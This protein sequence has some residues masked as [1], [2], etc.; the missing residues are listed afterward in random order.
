MAQYKTLKKGATD[1][2]VGPL[3]M[4]LNEALSPSPNL[5]TDTVF[6]ADT[7]RAVRRF[8]QENH[9]AEDGVVGSQTWKKLL[10]RSPDGILLASLSAVAASA[11]TVGASDPVGE[12]AGGLPDTAGLS[13]EHKFNVYLGYIQKAG[14]CTS[15]E[16]ALD[17]GERV[18]LGLRVTTNTRTNAGGG[19][20][21][22]RF[23]VLH[24]NGGVKTAKEF[25][26]NTDPSSRYEHRYE[27]ARKAYG[28]DANNDGR[29]DLGRIPAGS[30]KFKKD[31]S[32][33]YGNVLRPMSAIIAERDINHD[34]SFDATDVATNAAALNAGTSM[35]FH[36][37]GKNITG[38][39]GCQTMPPTTFQAFWT[40]LGSQRQFHYVLVKV[41]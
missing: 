13:E 21:D 18:I 9:L 28:E 32:S 35:L 17:T 24:N 39:A 1:L 27:H 6:D 41:K 31:Q 37:G 3:K 7:D 15:V 36:K 12:A 2:L 19:V 10:N 4:A 29:K 26:G 20:Y 11:P 25:Q 5:P 8:Q 38:S 40:A 22:D 34:G 14:Q 30:Y 33:T 16:A 23:V